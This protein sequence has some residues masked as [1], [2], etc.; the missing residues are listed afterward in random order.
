MGQGLVSKRFRGEDD[1]PLAAFRDIVLID[2]EGEARQRV[3]V[4]I[5]GKGL[6]PLDETWRQI[7]NMS[8]ALAPVLKD[9]KRRV[10]E[11]LLTS[12][13]TVLA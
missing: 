11:T 3:R 7:S 2:V 10:L 13:F 5:D 12:E 4:L 9:A 1:R 8:P 6:E